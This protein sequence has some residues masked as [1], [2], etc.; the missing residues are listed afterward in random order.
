MKTK[1]HVVSGF[2]HWKEMLIDIVK[3]SCIQYALNPVI[4]TLPQQ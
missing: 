1:F 4:F 2:G 3:I